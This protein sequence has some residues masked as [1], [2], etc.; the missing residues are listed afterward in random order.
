[1][2]VAFYFKNYEGRRPSFQADGPNPMVS[3]L[4]L[5]KRLDLGFLNW[6]MIYR[7]LT[8]WWRLEHMAVDRQKMQRH[9]NKGL[10]ER[11]ELLRRHIWSNTSGMFTTLTL[12]LKH[13]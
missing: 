1:M 13:R 10:D 6:A 3:V 5:G 8:K 11:F 12:Q 2:N 9:W 4:D 7:Q